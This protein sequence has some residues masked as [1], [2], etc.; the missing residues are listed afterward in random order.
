MDKMYGG[1]TYIDFFYHS[2]NIGFLS[3]EVSLK[4]FKDFP[5]GVA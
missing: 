5:S 3:K 2:I 1:K 4:F